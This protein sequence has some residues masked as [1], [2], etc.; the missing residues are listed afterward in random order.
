MPRPKHARSQDDGRPE[1]MTP[2]STECADQH[3][4]SKGLLVTVS[5]EGSDLASKE[6]DEEKGQ[7]DGGKGKGGKEKGRDEERKKGKDKMAIRWRES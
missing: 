4:H 7:K 5:G 2:L 1:A 6:E 3:V